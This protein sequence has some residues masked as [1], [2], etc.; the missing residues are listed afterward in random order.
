LLCATAAC[1]GDDGDDDTEQ[2]SGAARPGGGA[3]PSVETVV[4]SCEELCNAKAEAGCMRQTAESCISFCRSVTP[5]ISGSCRG[6]KLAAQECEL[7]MDDVCGIE[8]LDERTDA[9]ICEAEII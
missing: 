8:C 7:G 9:N 6:T 5:Y 3:G 1:G 4:A 2:S